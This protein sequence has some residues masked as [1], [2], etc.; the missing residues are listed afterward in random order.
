MKQGHATISI[1]SL[2]I[3]IFFSSCRT[4][5][6]LNEEEYLLKKNTIELTTKREGLNTDNLY[7]IARPKPT[8]RFLGVMPMKIWFYNLG[9]RGKESSKFRKW[10]RTSAGEKPTVYDSLTVAKSADEMEQYLNKSGYYGSDVRVKVNKEDQRAWVTYIITPAPPYKIREIKYP[11]QDTLLLGYILEYEQQSKL[12]AGDIFDIYKLDDKREGIKEF[13]RDNGYYYF[14]RNYIYYEADTTPGDRMVD[15]FLNVKRELGKELEGTRKEIPHSRYF[16]NQILIDPDF[17]PSRQD[18]KNYDTIRVMLPAAS[19]GDS[20]SPYYFLDDGYIRVKPKSIAQSIFLRQG[21][22]FSTTDVKKTRRRIQEIG[23]FGYA[24]IQFKEAENPRNDSLK[25]LN[26]TIEIQQ[27]KLN[28]FTVETEGTNN[29]GRP[30][31]AAIFSYQN[32]NLFRRAEIFQ[33]RLRGALEF[34]ST[35]AGQAPEQ[36]EG[37]LFSTVETGGEISIIFPRFIIPIGQEKFPKYFRP[38][39]ILKMG[40]NYERRPQY[41]RTIS[42]FNFGYEWRESDFKR[43]SLY[44]VDLNIVDVNMKPEFAEIVEN[45]PNDR[46]RNQYIDHMILA[47]NYS[48]TFN[49]QEL[50]KLKNFWY[51]RGVVEPAGNL[52]HLLKGTLGAERDSAGHYSLFSIRYAQYIRT[53]YDIR[54]YNL[55]NRDNS[56]VYRLFM[57]IGIPYGNS[58][59]LPLEKGFYGGGANGMRGWPL[60]LLGPGAYSNPDDRFDR[61]GDIQL[62]GNVEYRFPIYRFFEG[63]LFIDAGNIWLLSPND[64]YPGGEF[65][66]N[67]FFREIAMDAGFGLRL[68]FDFFIVRLDAAVPVRDPSEAAGQRWVFNKF[69][70]KDII[71]NLG[72]G[73][74]F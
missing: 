57:G 41:F 61:M 66:L 71:L 27:R 11:I 19:K 53:Q 62:E 32:Y 39:S 64:S 74:P 63:G 65:H 46:I 15:I 73:Y 24:G 7:S 28:A 60:R 34:Q 31:V 9:N 42:N 50:N 16:I 69:Q 51:F 26:C 55:I 4:T 38:K 8:K 23:L 47:L 54:F 72:I 52:I 45:E 35:L 18:E 40:L 1:V 59:V 67:D 14:S 49:N 3:V 12:K 13:L 30:G 68:N 36:T 21:D 48:Y 2:I 70:F 25:W 5:M 37:E 29:G 20:G 22:P 43:H 56:L 33:F 17:E 58:S 6:T 10:L 44:P